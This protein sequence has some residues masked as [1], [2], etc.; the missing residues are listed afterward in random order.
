VIRWGDDDQDSKYVL[1]RLQPGANPTIV[2]YNASVVKNCDATSSL[3]RFK[4]KN[5]L[6]YFEKNALAY[7]SAG[8]VVVKAEIAGLG[9]AAFEK[10]GTESLISVEKGLP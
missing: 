9:P 3:V 4:D 2:S 7:Y 5:E 10:R 8:V 6:S 1:A